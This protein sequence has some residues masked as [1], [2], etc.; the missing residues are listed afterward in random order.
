[1]ARTVGRTRLVLICLGIVLPLGGCNR[2]AQPPV[3]PAA[4]KAQAATDLD[5][6]PV[7]REFLANLPAD[8]NEVPAQDVAK[9]KPFIVD[10]RQPDDYA[11]GFLAG[12][13]NIPL[14]DLALSL[15]ALPGMDKDIVV[16]CNSG[17]RAAIGMAM[18]QM[19]GYKKTKSLEGG[20]EAWRQA[21]LSTVTGPVP[22]RPAGQ[23]PQ[24]NEQLQAALNYY[25]V[26]TLPVHEGAMSPAGLTEDQ[27]RKSSMELEEN[28]TF[29]QG[30]SVLMVVDGPDE[31]AKVHLTSGAMNFQLRGLVDS[32]E[33]LPPTGAT[34][35]AGACKVPNRFN[36]EPQ[37]T[38]FVV[39]ST[40]KHRA[41]L[42]MV[43]MQ[44]L[45]FHFVSALEGDMIAWRAGSPTA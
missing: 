15:Q 16:V 36:V 29:D 35:Y 12:A 8:W 13:V 18:L 7:V 22:A 24:V 21:K 41:A 11:K 27:Q 10:V 40:S 2:Q 33:T 37:L 39:V 17:H 45:G 43:S 38:R 3:A 30:R 23:P 32:A 31:F 14:R 26:R 42:G 9:A 25:L 34:Y 19:L 4:T 44:L 6:K 5:L 1:M 28:D 20:M